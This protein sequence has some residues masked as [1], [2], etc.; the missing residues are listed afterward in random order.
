MS[1]RPNWRPLHEILVAALQ[2]RAQHAHRFG[3][4][5]QRVQPR[6]VGKHTRH[7]TGKAQAR[8]GI[9]AHILERDV[10]VAAA[11]DAVACGQAQAGP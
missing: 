7:V 5:Q 9:D 1:G 6:T 2:H 10:T 4:E 8:I 11:I 3:A